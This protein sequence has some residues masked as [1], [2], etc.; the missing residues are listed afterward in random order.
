MT[1]WDQIRDRVGIVDGVHVPQSVDDPAGQPQCFEPS[2]LDRRGMVGTHRNFGEHAGHRPAN[3]DKPVTTIVGRTKNG[4]HTRRQES[5]RRAFE[6]RHAHLGSVHAD[7]EYRASGAFPRILDCSVKTLAEATPPLG[8]D[9]EPARGPNRRTHPRT[10]PPRLDSWNGQRLRA[11]P[12]MQPR[13]RPPPP[14]KSAAGKACLDRPR[15]WL[16][17]D[18]H[19]L[20]LAQR[21]CPGRRAIGRSDVIGG[22]PPCPQLPAPFPG[23][24]R[25]P[26]NDRSE[27]GRR[28]RPPKRSNPSGAHAGPFPAAT[29]I[30]DLRFRARSILAA[31]PR[32]SDRDRVTSER[33]G[34]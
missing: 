23:Q 11:C 19:D 18:D 13:P 7:E 2:A 30:V 29:P 31:G 14:M 27:P 3:T 20:H 25:S 28:P 24:C 17:G 21:R 34:V 16:L 22:E 10:P 1:S 5:R 12:P 33:C 9:D 32:A 4:V 6:I 26:S 15:Q 8:N